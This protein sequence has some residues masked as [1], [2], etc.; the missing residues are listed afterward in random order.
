[1]EELKM[2]KVIALLLAALM[3]FS[4]AACNGGNNANPPA[5]SGTPRGNNNTPNNVDPCDCCPDCDQKKCECAE[6]GGN[7]DCECS[8]PSGGIH[9]PLT[10]DIGIRIELLKDTDGDCPYPADCRFTTS[11]AAKV[12]MDWADSNNGYFGT[13]GDGFGEYVYFGSHYWDSDGKKMLGHVAPGTTFNFSAMLSIPNTGNDNVIKVGFNFS[14]EGDVTM[15]W[16]NGEVLP[17]PGMMDMVQG[18][19]SGKLE[20]MGF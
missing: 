20:I 5:N 14:G 15:N 13:S 19:F 2:K 11:G 1:L 4:L 8:A 6:C 18:W 17:F 10:Y 7:S 3:L 12:T 16:P 9:P